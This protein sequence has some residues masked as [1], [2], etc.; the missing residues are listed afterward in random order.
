MK[1]DELTNYF[2]EFWKVDKSAVKDSLM[3]DSKSV[4]GMSSIRLYQFL[5]SVESKFHVKIQNVNKIVTF[6]DLFRNIR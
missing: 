5:A 2:S 4:K 1:K 6:G 3:L